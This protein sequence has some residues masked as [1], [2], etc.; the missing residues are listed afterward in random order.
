MTGEQLESLVELVR[1]DLPEATVA[2]ERE[3]LRVGDLGL[4]AR[5]FA[6][7]PADVLTIER[8]W[9]ELA[10]WRDEVAALRA[11]ERLIPASR[12]R[13]LEGE[14]QVAAWIADGEEPLL[15]AR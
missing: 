14:A 7:D 12:R 10:F 3:R 1:I 15:R 13:E 6:R 8:C 11:L 9:V 5:L 4:E 2:C